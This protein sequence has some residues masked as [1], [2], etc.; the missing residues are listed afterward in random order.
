MLENHV[1]T[2]HCI[3]AVVERTPSTK[4]R[5][6]WL[7]IGTLYSF[8][9]LLWHF[10]LRE[11]TFPVWSLPFLDRSQLCLIQLPQ[12]S[13]RK[14]SRLTFLFFLDQNAIRLAISVSF[15]KTSRQPQPRF[16]T[17]ICI[18]LHSNEMHGRLSRIMNSKRLLFVRTIHILPCNREISDALRKV[19]KLLP[20][21]SPTECD[22]GD[23]T[24]PVDPLLLKDI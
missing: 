15:R 20:K 23:W 7:Q 18:I 2:K 5:K 21:S 8:A 11:S 17:G 14:R 10:K 1:N 3:R 22:L 12:P 19:I 24:S 4:Q 16:S 13:S 6:N 9:E